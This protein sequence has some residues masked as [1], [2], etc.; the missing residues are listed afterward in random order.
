M[1]RRCT[2]IKFHELNNHLQCRLCSRDNYG[3]FKAYEARRRELYGNDLVE[4]FLRYKRA[5][6]AKILSRSELIESIHKYKA[7]RGCLIRCHPRQATDHQLAHDH[8]NPRCARAGAVLVIFT[9]AAGAVEPPRGP[10][11]H[12]PLRA[13]RTPLG[14]LGPLHQLWPYGVLHRSA[15][16]H[17]TNWPAS[18]CAA[19]RQRRRA[20]RGRSGSRR[21]TAPSQSHPLAAVT[22]TARSH[23]TAS[24]R[25]WRPVTR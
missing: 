8:P 15:W 3:M 20:N 16:T 24:T 18:A 5:C 22:T 25:R 21:R 17:A 10:L 23:P 19:Q 11:D 1:T 9:Q 12:P 4:E 7:L 14:A 6:P 13:H 2:P